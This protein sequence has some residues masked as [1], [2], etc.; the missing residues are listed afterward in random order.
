[1]A[2]L[3]NTLKTVAVIVS[4]IVLILKATDSIITKVTKSDSKDN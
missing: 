2:I 3:L 1:M 4:E